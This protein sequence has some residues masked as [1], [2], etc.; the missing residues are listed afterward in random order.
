MYV[1]LLWAGAFILQS[2][3]CQW[4]IPSYFRFPSISV[5]PYFRTSLR[6]YEKFPQLTFSQQNIWCLSIKISDDLLLVSLFQIC[7][8]PYFRKIDTF[9]P[10][11]DKALFPIYFFKFP[12]IFIKVACFCLIYVFLTTSPILTVMHLCIMQYTYWTPLTVSWQ[13]SSF[14]KCLLEPFKV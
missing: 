2:Q 8:F 10:I 3:I 9:P 14:V 13:I 1:C 5:F 4:C 12:P 7:Y 6:G 11:W